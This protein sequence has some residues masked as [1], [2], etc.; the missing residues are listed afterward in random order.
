[1]QTKNAPPPDVEGGLVLKSHSTGTRSDRHE[2]LFCVHDLSDRFA[3]AACAAGAQVRGPIGHLFVQSDR[4]F[5]SVGLGRTVVT[6]ARDVVH[7]VA[8]DPV[9]VG[10]VLPR[11][12]DMHVPDFVHART[13]DETLVRVQED[14]LEEVAVLGDGQIGLLFEPGVLA[15]RI[16]QLATDA[17]QIDSVD[18]LLTGV[19]GHGH[20]NATPA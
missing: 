5:A 6:V 9:A 10:G 4:A 11:V 1:L 13:R 18:L 20:V 8:E 16:D 19:A 12:E 17:G 7:E 15:G 3:A 2:A 14:E